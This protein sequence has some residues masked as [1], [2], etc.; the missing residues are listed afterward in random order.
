M[1]DKSLD[2]WEAK[3]L[4]KKFVPDNVSVA[5]E[6]QHN[7]VRKT[8]FPPVHRV[9]KPNSL[10]TRDH[11]TERLNICIDHSDIIVRLYFG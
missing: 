5:A 2:N 3:L 7:V 1:S 9:I 11:R 4:G 10:I 6:E 8:D